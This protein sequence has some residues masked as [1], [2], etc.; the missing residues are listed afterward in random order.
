VHSLLRSGVEM[1]R[2]P[3]VFWDQ[4]EIDFPRSWSLLTSNIA[5]AAALVGASIGGNLYAAVYLGIPMFIVFFLLTMLLMGLMRIVPDARRSAARTAVAHASF[6]WLG[7]AI[8][9][10]ILAILSILTTGPRGPLMLLGGA[11]AL[12]PAGALVRV[13][14]AG[15]RA[16]RYVAEPD[17]AQPSEPMP[18]EPDPRRDEP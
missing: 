16:L 12:V 13:S 2:R 1:L 10:G 8:P 18:T 11:L 15:T 17:E 3:S 14:L 4:V 6:L 7:V 5:L 9:A